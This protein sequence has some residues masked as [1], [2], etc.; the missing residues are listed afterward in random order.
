MGEGVENHFE[1]T[2]FRV[3]GLYTD[4]RRP[5]QVSFVDN[6]VE[7]LARRDLTINA[8]AYN[9]ISKIVLD[10]FYGQQDLNSHII[11]A[12]GNPNDRFQED[13]LRIMRAARFAAR[14]NYQI[15]LK[16]FNGMTN[17]ISTLEKVSKERVKDE[18][19]KILMTE[20]PDFGIKILKDAGILD[21]IIPV[22]GRCVRWS[23]IPSYLKL[24]KGDLE[25]KL[26][27]LLYNGLSIPV[28][29][30]QLTDLKFSNLE[31][32]RVLFLIDLLDALELSE[33]DYDPND[34]KFFIAHIKNKGPDTW[35]YTLNQF[36]SFIE[37]LGGRFQDLVDMY[38]DEVIWARNEMQINGDD[39]MAIGIEPGPKLK[40][41]LNQCYN[42]II[43]HP[44]KNTKE[45]LMKFITLGE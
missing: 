13:G 7:D 28:I 30:K 17:N 9:P 35:Q 1:V 2:T 36:I 5:E 41:V 44:E 42:Q 33:M 21:K 25:T 18:L 29:K 11:R 20:H 22:I 37:A 45:Q 4:G 27:V 23:N 19:C 3:E 40:F 15:E 39:L 12:V 31:I 38:K 6:I 34:Y 8:M 14:F 32:K 26:A 24:C 16:T 10:P 43:F